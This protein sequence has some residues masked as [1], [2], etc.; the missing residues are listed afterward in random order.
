[1]GLPG[2][3]M[4]VYPHLQEIGGAVTGKAGFSCG[5]WM[6]LAPSPFSG[7]HLSSEVHHSSIVFCRV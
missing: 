4:T 7:R 2:G 1:M 5:G 3:L 6:P